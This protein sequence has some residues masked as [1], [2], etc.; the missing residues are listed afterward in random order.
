MI[1]LDCPSCG[2]KGYAPH[3]QAESRLVCKKCQVVFHMTST[4]RLELGEPPNSGRSSRDT[5]RSTQ[6]TATK[7][8]KAATPRES[9]EFGLPEFKVT[10]LQAKIGVGVAVLLAVGYFLIQDHPPEPL[11]YRAQKAADSVV[12]DDLPSLKGLADS[13]AQDALAKWYETAH[14]KIE[15]LKKDSPGRP[16][17]TTVLVNGEDRA[18]KAGAAVLYVNLGSPTGAAAKSTK[19]A[20]LTLEIP[21]LWTLSGNRWVLDGKKLE[22]S[23]GGIH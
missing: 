7:K 5:N 8:A 13:Q 9:A 3:V 10:P 22:E 4:G 20:K 1:E 18:A 14:G 15:Q 11:S 16:V 17:M 6:A 21:L 2:R 12:A 23:A 19:A